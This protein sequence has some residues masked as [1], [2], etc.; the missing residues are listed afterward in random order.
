LVPFPGGRETWGGGGRGVMIEKKEGREP[1]ADD[2]DD[3]L[4]GGVNCE[5]PKKEVSMRR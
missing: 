4:R 3:A 5:M 2:P 1:S